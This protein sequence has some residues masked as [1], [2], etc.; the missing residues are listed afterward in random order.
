MKIHIYAPVSIIV[1]ESNVKTANVTP[2]QRLHML[3][4]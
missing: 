2:T 4:V 1:Y 3:A